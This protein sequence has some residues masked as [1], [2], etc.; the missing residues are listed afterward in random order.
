MNNESLLKQGL[1]ELNIPCSEDQLKAFM[2]LLSELKK[3]NKAYNLTALKTDKDIIIKHFIDSLLYLNAIPETVIKLADA[4]AGPGFPGIPLKI[5][6]P[7]IEMTL[8]EPTRKK[9]TF[10]R[11]MI[12]I[13]NLPTIDVMEDRIENLDK[14]HEEKYD[15]IVSRA[16]FSI[17]KF[18]D[19]ACPYIK[20][21]GILV[22]SKGP[23][24]SEDLDELR[25][26]PYTEKA[27]QKI[28]PVKLPLTD[29][30]RS[31]VILKCPTNVTNS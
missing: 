14:E 27:I 16:T 17:T 3:W 8:I 19:S 31:I 12:R 22:M 9:A 5:I 21:N 18:L 4:G 13:L 30:E 25:K 29:T 1:Q 11:Q 24:L 28:D 7:D 26:S 10:L 15:I 2:T 6:R 23:K 20:S